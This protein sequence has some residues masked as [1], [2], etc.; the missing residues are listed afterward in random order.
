MSY[1]V[2]LLVLVVLV[3]VV[4]TAL[5]LLRMDSLIEVFKSMKLLALKERTGGFPPLPELA[6]EQVRISSTERTVCSESLNNDGG[7][8]PDPEG[9]Q[10]SGVERGYAGHAMEQPD[11]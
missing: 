5:W 8:A 3:M 11:T 10:P 7:L 1:I 6:Y 2:V 4:I 9:I